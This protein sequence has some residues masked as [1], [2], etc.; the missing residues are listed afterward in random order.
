MNSLSLPYSTGTWFAV[1]LVKNG[2]GVGVVARASSKGKIFLGF[3]FGPVRASVPKLSEVEKLK[4][5]DAIGVLRV[6][7][8][9][10]MAKGWPIIGKSKTWNLKEWPVPQFIRQDPLSH[11]AWKV[12][13]CDADMIAP[14]SEQPIAY[15]VALEKDAVLGSG[16]LELLL[17]KLLYN[18]NY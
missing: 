8:L 2:F 18:N 17:T 11:K 13:Y 16:A 9:S 15:D 7:D 1:P 12:T 6:G 4:P 14:M 5:A 10:L 3:F